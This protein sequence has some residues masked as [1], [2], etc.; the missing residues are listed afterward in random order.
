VYLPPADA[1]AAFERGSVDAWVIWDPYQAAAEQQ[2]QAR[3]LRDGKGLVDNHQFYLAT[4]YAT[5]HPAVINTL[6]EEVRAVGEW[7]QANPQEVTD[8]VAPLLGLPADITLT[9]VKRQ[10]YGAR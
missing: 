2:L 1:R 7:S 5:Q 9:S 3:T 6:V 10:G 4:R 8:Q